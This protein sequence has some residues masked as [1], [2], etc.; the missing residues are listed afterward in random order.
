MQ[1]CDFDYEI[2]IH[3]DASVDRTA[4]IIREYELKYPAI[5]RP[6][7]QKE[8]QYSKGQRGISLKY[9]FPRARGKY[10]ALCEGDD[11]WTDSL[12]LQKQVEFLENHPKISLTC[13]GY[14]V[15]RNNEFEEMIYPYKGDSLKTRRKGFE[16]GLTLISEPWLTKTLTVVFRKDFYD[17]N[18]IDK[19]SNYRDVHLFYHLLREGNGYYFQEVFGVYNVHQGGVHSLISDKDKIEKG[20]SIYKELYDINKDEYLR[21]KLL[22]WVIAKILSKSYPKKIPH[23]LE[24]IKLLRKPQDIFMFFKRLAVKLI[25][26]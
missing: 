11:Y 7:Y 22:S 1:Q 19:Y 2:L 4:D 13:G 10:I 16:F 14:K 9:N 25:K 6:I 12:K 5:I 24:Y 18:L 26:P 15:L 20:Y 17:V 23:I 8:N 3:D 21:R